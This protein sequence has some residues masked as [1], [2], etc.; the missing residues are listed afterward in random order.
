MGESEF[1]LSQMPSRL[2]T[3]TPSLFLAN[4]NTEELPHLLCLGCAQEKGLLGRVRSPRVQGPLSG[5][6]TDALQTR[7]AA[8]G[9]EPSLSATSC[10]FILL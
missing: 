9:S 3:F 1:F 7:W 5:T 10:L 2:H 8:L 6:L 4:L